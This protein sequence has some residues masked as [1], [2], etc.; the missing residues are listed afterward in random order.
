MIF[1]V[2]IPLSQLLNQANGPM[3][4]SIQSNVYLALS[5]LVCPHP[6][7][8]ELANNGKCDVSCAITFS[9]IPNIP[10]LI[11]SLS[12]VFFF[13]FGSGIALMRPVIMMGAETPA[14]QRAELTP[15]LIVRWQNAEQSTTMTTVTLSA[16]TPGVSTMETT[17][18][19]PV[20]VPAMSQC[21]LRTW[22]SVISNYL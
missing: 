4:F 7:C 5:H 1:I 16:I 6:N 22:L 8:T 9:H 20:T 13:K 19:Q 21:A 17:V 14:T 12:V 11:L 3:N 15:G 10:L 18:T 2:M